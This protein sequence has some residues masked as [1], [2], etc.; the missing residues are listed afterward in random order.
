MSSYDVKRFIVISIDHVTEETAAFLNKTPAADWPC[1]GGPYGEYGWFFYAHDQN[2]GL[3][4]HRI[5]DDL[6]AVMTW[7]REAGF[8]HILLDCDAE[9]MD[10]LPIFDS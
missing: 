1:L 3:G 4:E 7:A 10:G 6:L 9:E 5:P 8:D 2:A